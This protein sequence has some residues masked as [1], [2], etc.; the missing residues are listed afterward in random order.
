MHTQIAPKVLQFAIIFILLLASVF[1]FFS[2]RRAVQQQDYLNAL[3]SLSFNKYLDRPAGYSSV[4]HIGSW[5]AYVFTAPEFQC[6]TGGPYVILV[7]RGMQADKTI[8]WLEVGEEC[9]PDH[10]LCGV[11]DTQL[12]QAGILQYLVKGVDISPF[13]PTSADKANPVAQWNYVYLPTCDGSWHFGDSAADYDED[14]VPDHWHN[15]LRQTS[16]G[17]NLIRQLF[18]NSQKILVFGS[19]NGGFGTFGAAPVVR[20]AFPQIPLYVLDDSGPGIFSPD[21]PDVWPEIQ[22]TWN[23]APMFPSDCPKCVQQ[24]AYLS[25]WML[26][27][28]PNLKVGLFTSYQDAVVSAV[29]GMDPEENQRLMLQVT[30]EIHQ[31]NP[32]RY[33][34]FIVKG[35]SH[36]INDYYRN[37]DGVTVWDWLG[38][39]VQDDPRWADHL[40]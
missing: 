11:D 33:Q 20:L 13:G 19:S 18:P 30:G 21:R 3:K 2:I 12:T 16:A 28:D 15:G 1:A 5:D 10:P 27:R 39:L 17:V 7:H 25:D 34:R 23:L 29:L 4:S 36:C 37:V 6:V 40:Q 26:Q 22:K 9:W 31:N 32:T 14:G 8:L 38:S 35:A 24:L